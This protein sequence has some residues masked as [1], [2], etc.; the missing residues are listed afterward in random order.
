MNRA[1]AFEV[2]ADGWQAEAETVQA[3]RAAARVCLEETLNDDVR[4]Y[5]N[6]TWWETLRRGPLGMV[7]TTTQGRP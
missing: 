4:I 7:L 3:A 1:L 2:V 5:R 6:G